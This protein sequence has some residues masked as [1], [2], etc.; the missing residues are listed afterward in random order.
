M[1]SYTKKNKEREILNF[2]QI[3]I[4]ASLSDFTDLFTEVELEKIDLSKKIFVRNNE[5]II[6]PENWEQHKETFFNQRIATYKNDYTFAEKIKLEVSKLKNLNTKINDYKVLKDRYNIFLEQKQPN[7]EP[8]PPHPINSKTDI[9][10]YKTKHY[11]LAYLFECNAK[12]ESF[13]LS[14]KKEL[15]RIGNERMKAG[16]GNTFYKVFNKVIRKDLNVKE[17]LFEIGGEYWRRAVIELSK[18]PELVETYLQS[19]QL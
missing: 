9:G 3:Q 5:S 11:V 8:L 13:P 19:K 4:E 17:D 15:E 16:N 2:F 10:K 7:I 14:N 6:T 18:A 12:G 1:N